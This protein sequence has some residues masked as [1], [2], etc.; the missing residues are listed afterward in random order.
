[1]LR[2]VLK[3]QV[4]FN[5]T[6]AVFKSTLHPKVNEYFLDD[7]KHPDQSKVPFEKVNSLFELSSKNLKNE[8]KELD[9]GDLVVEYNHPSNIYDFE[10]T[11]PKL[12]NFKNEAKIDYNKDI[13]RVFLYEK[14]AMDKNISKDFMTSF[15]AL[16]GKV[17]ALTFPKNENA[18]FKDGRKNYNSLDPFHQESLNTHDDGFFC[19]DAG[20]ELAKFGDILDH[21]MIGGKFTVLEYLENSRLIP[22]TVPIILD[23]NTIMRFRF[24]FNSQ[25]A[26]NVYGTDKPS[27]EKSED[28]EAVRQKTLEHNNPLTWIKCGSLLNNDV[29]K[30][31]PEFQ[32]FDLRRNKNM[33]DVK[34][35]MDIKLPKNLADLETY[36][37]I[38]KDIPRKD[39]TIDDLK[40]TKYSIMIM[41]PDVIEY[42]RASFKSRLNYMLSDIQITDMNDNFVSEFKEGVEVV[43]SYIPPLPMNGQPPQRFIMLLFE[44]PKDMD[45]A[46]LKEKVSSLD[47]EDDFDVRELI[48]EF[49]L[50]PIGANAFRAKYDSFMPMA[51]THH[52]WNKELEFYVES[53]KD[54][55]R[56]YVKKDK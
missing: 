8:L 42:E 53:D 32:I 34:A 25:S 22:D 7:S 45:V 6:S 33:I 2:Q 15:S 13:N 54:D 46:A 4:R 5:S 24:P 40:K 10:N 51:A 38:L 37:D 17:N 49:N 50:D 52:S 23:V 36:E 1:M 43:Q 44:Q 41:T 28:F 35:L 11:T 3:K 12:H 48:K 55:V 18:P 39:I 29:V 27:F 47:V 20:K 14:W 56:Y 16:K 21:D 31:V 30:S 9:G 19:K 26:F